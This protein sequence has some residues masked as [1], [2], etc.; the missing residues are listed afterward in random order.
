MFTAILLAAAF[1]TP[2]GTSTAEATKAAP[3]PP[4]GWE[5]P[6]PLAS[7]DAGKKK[8]GKIEPAA[9][10]VYDDICCSR[11]LEMDHAGSNHEGRIFE[12]RFADLPD[13]VVKEAPADG[14]GIEGAPAVRVIDGRGRPYPWP[15]EARDDVRVMPPGPLGEVKWRSDYPEPFFEDPQYRGMGYGAIH[16][17]YG[18]REGAATALTGAVE[19]AS[20]KAGP[21]GKVIV[22]R[23]KGKLEGTPAVHATYWA[24]AEAVPVMPGVT[25]AYRIRDKDGERVVFVLPEVV[26][27]FESKDTKTDGGFLPSRFSRSWSFTTYTMPVGPGRSGLSTFLIHDYLVA[28]WFPPKGGVPK[29]EES[30]LAML[31]SSQTSVEAEPRLRLVLFEELHEEQVTFPR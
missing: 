10:C 8:K 9:C 17:F 26:L 15:D 2:P 25:N 24:H 12:V 20:F 3:A 30:I 11:Q 31:A 1:L 29:L 14:P 19:F 28:R 23:V 18:K 5:A 7:A 13:L 4:A 27:G 16:E 6:P 21:D 22:D